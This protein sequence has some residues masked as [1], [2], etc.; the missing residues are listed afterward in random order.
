MI[1][2]NGFFILYFTRNLL[3]LQQNEL[4]NFFLHL[5]MMFLYYHNC[6]F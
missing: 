5:M 6:K 4:I 1:F 2:G 3:S